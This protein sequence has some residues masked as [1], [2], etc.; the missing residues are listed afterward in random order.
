MVDAHGKAASRTR[1]V[2]MNGQQG[3]TSFFINSDPDYSPGERSALPKLLA[4]GYSIVSVTSSAD[5]NSTM[6][7]IVLQN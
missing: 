3:G 6:F 1:L 4:Q 7:A 2:L 5:A